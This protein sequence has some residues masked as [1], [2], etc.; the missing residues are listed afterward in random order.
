MKFVRLRRALESAAVLIFSA[1]AAEA[2]GSTVD[3][4]QL[5]AHPTP[6]ELDAVRANWAARPTATQ[7]FQLEASGFDT[8][9][10][11][12]DVISHVVDGER[13]YGAV[14]FPRNYVAGG[15]YPVVIV[16][17]G[18]QSGIMLDELIGFLALFPTDCIEENS[19][20][21][22]PSFRGESLV[23]GFAGTFTST[24]A[25]SI[26]DRDVDDTLGLLSAALDNYPE[27]DVARVAAYGLS[28]GGTASLLAS[29]RDPRIRRVVDLFAFTDLSLPAVRAEIERIVDQGAPPAG[30][31]GVAYE[32][33]VEPWIN[34]TMSLA[35][36]RS[37]WIR[38]S[39]CF[40][41][42]DLPRIQVHHGLSDIQVD[43][44]HST[45]ILDALGQL[46]LGAPEVEG[47]FYP[48]GMH[49][50]QSFVGHGARVEEFLCSFRDGPAGYCGPMRTNALGEFTAAD[51]A[52]SC[53]LGE[54]DFTFL[55]HRCSPN[56]FGLLFASA[57]TAYVAS[58]AGYL[59]VGHGLQRVGLA[60]TNASGE[61]AQHV[62]FDTTNSL[63]AP[64]FTVGDDVYFQ[65]VYRDAGN[66]NGAFN[67]SNGL[68][69]TLLP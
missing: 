66:P 44:S 6:Q 25:P 1:A 68:A 49:D 50:P 32:A 14:R 35:D 16:A 40:F 62:D 30:I 37:E 39:P 65:V 15:V 51:Y 21:L 34:G 23:T 69:V 13:H 56:S 57:E 28:R 45:A 36:A 48:G 29:I 17:H 52:G 22:L 59:C 7:G 60:P 27:M 3:L 19:F 42:V 33:F 18:G 41:A 67:F 8:T 38:R 24:G 5:F 43:A 26:A 58:G 54:N 9:G 53:S 20:F 12:T 11:A 10:V 61:F 31:G 46:G 64:L 55:A 47:F 2:Q 4:T 63:L